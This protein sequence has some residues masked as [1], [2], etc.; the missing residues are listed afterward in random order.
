MQFGELDDKGREVAYGVVLDKYSDESMYTTYEQAAEDIT[1][2]ARD[3]GLTLTDFQ[4]G[5]F[6]MNFD[7]PDRPYGDASEGEFPIDNYVK[8]LLTGELIPLSVDALINACRW[9]ARCSNDVSKSE[10][11]TDN[12]R[13]AVIRELA[14]VYHDFVASDREFMET[15]DWAEMFADANGMVFDS[16]GKD[17]THLLSEHIIYNVITY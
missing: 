3:L 1:G 8:E 17:A 7:I 12:A 4:P 15:Q 5:E 11:E 14:R 2:Y 16:K 6:C 10:C 13:L 9:L